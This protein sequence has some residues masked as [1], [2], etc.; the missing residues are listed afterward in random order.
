MGTLFDQIILDVSQRA[1][2]HQ[3]GREG[4]GGVGWGVGGD[5]S[6]TL[7]KSYQCHVD[8]LACIHVVCLTAGRAAAAL[9]RCVGA[10]A[11]F[12]YEGA[13]AAAHFIGESALKVT[14]ITGL[15]FDN[16]FEYLFYFFQFCFFYSSLIFPILIIISIMNN[17]YF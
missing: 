10:G 11:K 13:E 4:G 16:P 9:M 7:R 17:I 15:F 6:F 2:T 3:E 1:S 8:P 5:E 12:T 14:G